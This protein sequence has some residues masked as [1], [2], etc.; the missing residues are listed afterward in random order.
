MME[1]V[2]D[3]SFGLKFESFYLN[4][5]NFCKMESVLFSLTSGFL[6]GYILN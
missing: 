5:F 1:I 2:F 3:I 4:L 6:F